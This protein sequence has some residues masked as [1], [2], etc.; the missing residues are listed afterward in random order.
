MLFMRTTWRATCFG[1]LALGP[2]LTA[3][4][5]DDDSAK[6]EAAASSSSSSS[7]AP[8]SGV[9]GQ[10]TDPDAGNPSEVATDAPSAPSSPPATSSATAQPSGASVAPRLT[11]YGWNA[12]LGAV[13]AGGIV[14]SIVESGGRCTLT[15]TLGGTTADASSEAI[16]NVTSTSCGEMLVPGDRLSPGTW[17]AVL[18]YESATA[19]GTSAPVDIEVP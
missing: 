2:L 13:E 4:G 6:G 10:P 14:P 9:Y 17:R 5:S 7:G 16:D 3:C 11:Y 19:D 8:R 1:I 15:L 12:D 18:T